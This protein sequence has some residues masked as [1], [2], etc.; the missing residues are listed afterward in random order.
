MNMFI[1]QNVRF[2]NN[3]W[4]IIYSGWNV[5]NLERLLGI[6]DVGVFILLFWSFF[7]IIVDIIEFIL[8]S[9]FSLN[10]IKIIQPNWTSSYTV[11][12]RSFELLQFFIRNLKLLLLFRCFSIK[13][14]CFNIIILQKKH[15]ILLLRCWR[16]TRFC[17]T[18]LRFNRW[19]KISFMNF[20]GSYHWYFLFRGVVLIYKGLWIFYR[21]FLDISVMTLF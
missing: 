3:R 5:I 1:P 15:R 9:Q 20:H 10:R 16:L 7:F 19:I 12:L 17:D 21:G 6:L 18:S 11:Y 2:A 8:T 14:N 13:I 4:L